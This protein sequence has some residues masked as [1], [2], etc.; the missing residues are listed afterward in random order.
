VIPS[1]P[2]RKNSVLILTSL[3]LPSPRCTTALLGCGD[4]FTLPDTRRSFLVRVVHESSALSHEDSL[5]SR[6]AKSCES[7]LPKYLQ[8]CT[9][10]TPHDHDL[11][12]RCV[13][14]RRS[15]VFKPC[16]R[17][18]FIF[19]VDRIKYLRSPLIRTFLSKFGHQ[20]I[21]LLHSWSSLQAFPPMVWSVLKGWGISMAKGCSLSTTQSPR[22]HLDNPSASTYS[23]PHR[24]LV[25]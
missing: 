14:P 11:P 25:P 1:S 23:I 8:K 22:L 19:R 4:P 12:N 21:N 3:G 17:F 16:K 2:L 15:V 6:R 10:P 9:C 20:W 24:P 13:V 5:V 18:R 7:K